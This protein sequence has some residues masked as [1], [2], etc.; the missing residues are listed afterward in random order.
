MTVGMLVILPK[1][2]TTNHYIFVALV[3]KKEKCLIFNAHV[4]I[5]WKIMGSDNVQCNTIGYSLKCT[6]YL[7]LLQ[8]ILDVCLTKIIVIGYR[9]V[10]GR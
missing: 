5:T 7:G 8:K 10:L 6:F 9:A 4:F 3:L 2:A 1:L